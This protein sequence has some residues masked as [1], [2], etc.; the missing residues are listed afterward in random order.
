MYTE[1]EEN[2][3][4]NFEYDDAYWNKD[5]TANADK[6]YK[7]SPHQFVDKWDTPI[8]VIHG[9]MDYRINAIFQPS[10][11]SSPMRTTGY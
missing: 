1:T 5:R 8:L 10:C 11:S 9:E 6:T 4:S 3:F 2:W 7:N